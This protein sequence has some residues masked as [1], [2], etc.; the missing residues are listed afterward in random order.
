MWNHIDSTLAELFSALDGGPL[1]DEMIARE[2][3]REL[4]SMTVANLP[5]RYRS[6]LERKYVA[7][8]S[9]DELARD[10]AVTPDAVKSLLARAR[11]AF[12][13]TFHTLSQAMVLEARR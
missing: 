3:T 10:L 7:G 11:R 4:V 5:E 2:E 1:S 9:L 12:R 8:E 6:V 13:A